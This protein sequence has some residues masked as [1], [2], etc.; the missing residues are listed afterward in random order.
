MPT[1]ISCLTRWLPRAAAGAWVAIAAVSASAATWT[2]DTNP[3][4]C[5]SGTNGVVAQGA[6]CGGSPGLTVSGWTSGSGTTASPTST[7]SFSAAY[8]MDYG[9]LGIISTNENSGTTTNPSAGTGPHAVDNRYGTELVLLQFATAV[10]LSNVTI[11]WNGTDNATGTGTYDYK[12]SDISVMAWLGSVPG[13]L[14]HTSGT[15]GGLSTTTNYTSATSGWKSIGGYLDVG[16]TAGNSVATGN[17]TIYST[18]WL[19]S[20]YNSAWSG[21]PANVD[22]DAFKLLA[23]TGATCA[24]TLTGNSCGT[25]P[26]PPGVPEPGS[27]ALL[28]AAGLGLLTARRRRAA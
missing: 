14:S 20:A 9:N 7:T 24:Q 16:A 27:L 21:G 15:V 8:L 25:T 1:S 12:D 2:L 18:Y 13:T 22:V 6:S 3:T 4:N 5:P 11:G 10:N 19:V 17:S 23:V 26:P 28:A